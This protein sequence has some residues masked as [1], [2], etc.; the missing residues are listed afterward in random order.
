M[1]NDH[2]TMVRSSRIARESTAIA[3]TR[4][5]SMRA[6]LVEGEACRIG[7]ATLHCAHFS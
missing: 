5:T 2:E 4:P 6:R 1:R 3:I 7:A